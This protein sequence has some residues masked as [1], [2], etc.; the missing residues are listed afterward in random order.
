MSVTAG[1]NQR[2]GNGRVQIDELDYQ[3]LQLLQEDG[4]MSYSA[5]SSRLSVPE[6]TVRS[7]VNRLLESGVLRIVGV[8][9]PFRVGYETIAIIGLQVQLSRLE[10]VAEALSLLHPVTFVAFTAGTYNI[11]AEVYLQTT[12]ELAEFVN[13]SLAGI[14]G[15]EKC[16]VLVELKR[17]KNTP[18]WYKKMQKTRK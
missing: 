2:D 16:D 11:V 8:V 14:D 3:L 15:I 1:D 18:F 17:H 9:N 13:E 10:S 12:D 6:S 5:M 4:R 7:R